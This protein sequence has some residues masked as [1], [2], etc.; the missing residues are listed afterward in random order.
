MPVFCNA[1]GSQV[2]PQ[3]NVCP[4]CGRPIAAAVGLPSRLGRHLRTLGI[5]WTIAG[6][7]CLIPAFTF[8]MV[9]R[10]ARVAVP[11][12]EE[13]ARTV[14]PVVLSIIG[15]LFFILAAG[16]LVVG[17]GLLQRKPWG[18]FLAIVL[19]I[20]SLIH[21]PFGTALGIYTL[22]VLLPPQGGTEY[23]RLAG[24]I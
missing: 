16:G 4:N 14:G 5:L 24:A 22:W 19:G 11:A 7:L 18:R 17:W 2:Q 10:I 20:L 21:P 9:S 3:F 1:C 23:H 12:S 6:A 13:V 15:G 8:T